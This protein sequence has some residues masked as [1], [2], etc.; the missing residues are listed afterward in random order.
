MNFAIATFNAE[1][2]DYA[3]GFELRL[4]AL[5]PILLALG[6][7]VLCLQ[8]VNAPRETHHGE[9]GFTP[10]DALLRGTP[11]APYHRAAS[12][13]PGSSAP[14][15][16]HNL[17]VLS[18]FPIIETRQIHHDLVPRWDWVPPG[19]TAPVRAQ[20]DRPILYVQAATDAG[21][22]HVLNLHLRAP[23]AA[24]LPRDK[25]RGQWTSSAGWAKGMFLAAQLR[26]AQAL[27]ARL[28]AEQIFDRE[29]QA[30]ILVCGD[31]NAD[32]YE[33]PTRILCGAADDLD[34]AAFA[35]RRLERLEARVPQARR[36]T[37]IH[38]GRRVLLD[39]ILASPALAGACSSVE[40]F[41]EGLMDEA[42]A[43][44]QVEG[45]LHAPIVARFA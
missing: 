23:R 33:T 16:V 17:V 40:I 43:P 11:Y 14:A 34:D 28:F 41:N 35:Q 7:D 30:R 12:T 25:T 29:P 15:D 32:S 39:H 10:L 27:E 22:L 1:N 6:A 45:S 13:R 31:F 37:V 36:H 21:P 18:R 24:H 4:K 3:Q 42:R 8:E 38:A 26:Q 9:R 2:L 5:R 44:E 20:F 19:E